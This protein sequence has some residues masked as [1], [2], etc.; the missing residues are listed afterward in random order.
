VVD[1]STSGIVTELP[2]GARD[3]KVDLRE[4]PEAIHWISFGLPITNNL[5]LVLSINDVVHVTIVVTW[6]R[7]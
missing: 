6:S 3:I 7:E 1:L 2:F 5:A 4:L